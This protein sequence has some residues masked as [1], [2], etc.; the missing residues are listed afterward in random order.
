MAMPPSIYDWVKEQE[1]LFETQEIQVGDNWWWSFRKHVQLIFHLKN[2]IFFLGEN[3]WLRAFKNI[4][5]PILNLAYWSEDIEVKDV[6]FYEDEGERVN[7]FLIKK[8]H[9]EVYVREH[10]L[11]TL[12]DE[13]TECDVD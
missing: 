8:Y 9:D 12:F 1:T 7:S 4:M 3:R 10:N 5:E 13:I 2:G 6:I 11:D